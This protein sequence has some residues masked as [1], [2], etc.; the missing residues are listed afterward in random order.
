MYRESKR[1]RVEYRAIATVDNKD[2]SDPKR[3]MGKFAWEGSMYHLTGVFAAEAAITILRDDTEARKMGG[4]LLT[5]AT[6]GVAYIERLRKAG[7]K[8]DAMVMP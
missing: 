2:P 5:P 7:V 6:L 3:V 8:M 1:D 4:G